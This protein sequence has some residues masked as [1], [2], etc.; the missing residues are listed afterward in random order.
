MYMVVGRLSVAELVRF[1]LA[2]LLA[3]A[4]AAKLAAGANGR[5]ALRSY[6]I[7]NGQL[8]AGVW[9]L[10]IL[11]ETGLAVAVAASVP[12][13]AE[14]AAALF[15]LFALVLIIALARGRSG[16]PCGCLGAR[17]RISWTGAARTAGLAAVFA[18]LPLLPDERPSTQAWLVFGLVVALAGVGLLTVAL[19]ALARETGELRL[20]LAPQ[21]ALS[22][23]HEGPRLGSRTAL[24][25]RFSRGPALALAV[26]TSS[27][28]RLCE[29]LEPALRL[30]ASD[31]KVELE[32]FEERR[33]NELWRALR[34]PGSPYG[35]VVDAAGTV[36]AKG[37]FNTL[38]QLEGLLATAERRTYEHVYA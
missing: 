23:E 18:V 9:A 20:A 5:A 10:L 36:L 4:A 19:L 17:S 15:A 29:A 1:V 11:A 31:P 14:A 27:G 24:H 8:R 13:A 28:C 32:V 34:I 38:M 25:A 37:A 30:V 7:S 2:V 35:V 16:A 3:S 22:L 21:A 6:G 33:D 12:L 26:F